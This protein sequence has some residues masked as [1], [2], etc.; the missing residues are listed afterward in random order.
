MRHVSRATAG[1]RALFRKQQEEK[2][3][4]QRL[5]AYLDATIEGH[6]AA[7]MDRLSAIRAARA[8][9]GS[10]EPIKDHTRDVGWETTLESTWRDVLYSLRRLEREGLIK[11]DWRLTENNRRAKYYTLTAQGRVTLRRETRDLEVQTAAISRIL[12]ASIV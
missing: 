9:M 6:V 2:E 10:L 3:L 4:D 12:R 1:L 8:E 7:G 11:G 5:R